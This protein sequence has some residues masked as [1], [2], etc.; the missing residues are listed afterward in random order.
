MDELEYDD[1]VH[2]LALED[3]GLFHSIMFEANKA[4][5]RKAARRL[6]KQLK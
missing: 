4:I 1:M 5:Q 2:F 3:Y 6:A